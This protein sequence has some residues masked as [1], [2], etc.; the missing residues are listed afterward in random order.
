[1]PLQLIGN[2]G[3]PSSTFPLAKCQG[4]CDSD[5]ECAYGLVCYQ[6]EYANAVP[7]CS[8][9]PSANH[10]YCIDPADLSQTVALNGR[11]TENFGLKLYWQDTYVWQD[12][13]FVDLKWCMKCDDMKPECYAGQ[14]VF[15]TQCET[16]STIDEPTEWQFVYLPSNAF[17]IK[18]LSSDLCLTLPTDTRLPLTVQQCSPFNEYQLFF[19][20][21]GQ[22]AF[23]DK[24]EIHPARAFDKCLG[25]T[26]HPKF[27]ERIFAW[28][29]EWSRAW[30]TALWNFYDL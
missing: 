11:A 20:L 18:I 8:G 3:Y 23:G 7:G 30:T 13:P 26:H 12:Q 17:H 14:T 27:G 24:F 9:T 10:D 5:A 29:C 19:A 1:L 16:N 2:N 25:N 22:A 21:N 6:R 15:L 4:D 28:P